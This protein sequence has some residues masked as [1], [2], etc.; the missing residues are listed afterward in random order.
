MEF[1]QNDI[2]SLALV[3]WKEA[4]GE[5]QPMGCDAVMH[6]IL[7]RVGA[8]GF[9]HTLHDVIYGK[10]Q[11]TSMSVPSDPEFNLQPKAG[12]VAFNN[13][14]EYAKALL[15]TKADITITIDVTKG[16]HYYANLKNVTLGW[17]F[18]N[19]VQ[20]P[21]QHPITAQIGLHTFFQ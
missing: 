10:N 16:A 19:I 13:C 3:A 5:A 21:T 4:R 9:A 14:L 8:P 20:N 18:R 2:H 17:F 1:D 15:G 11:F 7:N 6:V 12:D